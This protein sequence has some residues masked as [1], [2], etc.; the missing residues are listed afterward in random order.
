M[1]KPLYAGVAG[2]LVVAAATQVVFEFRPEAT[3]I[4]RVEICRA[5]DLLN[6]PE[7]HEH[8][9]SPQPANGRLLVT[10]AST[11]ASVSSTSALIVTPFKIT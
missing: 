8:Q 6:L 4:P 1:S 3:C 10:M 2:A 9:H 11:T 7:G 5:S